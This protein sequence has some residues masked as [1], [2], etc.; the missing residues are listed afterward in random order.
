MSILVEVELSGPSSLLIYRCLGS[1]TERHG[2]RIYPAFLLSN[3]P[4]PIRVT[5]GVPGTDSRRNAEE[6]VASYLEWIEHTVD[7]A[8]RSRLGT[9]GAPKPT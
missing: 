9:T 7:V 4:D 3:D 2:M 6:V 5:V 8:D 1:L